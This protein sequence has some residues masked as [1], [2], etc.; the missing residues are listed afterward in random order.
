MLPVI[1]EV[2]LAAFLMTAKLAALLGNFE[3]AVLNEFFNATPEL[4]RI[5]A[6]CRRFAVWKFQ[7]GIMVNRLLLAALALIV[8][9]TP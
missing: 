3:E 4:L 1:N 9:L 7:P 2:V 5:N 6:V 8:P